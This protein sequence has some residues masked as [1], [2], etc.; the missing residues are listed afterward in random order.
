[1]RP[2]FTERMIIGLVIMRVVITGFVIP[3]FVF[4]I[5]IVGHQPPGVAYV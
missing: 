1:M 2:L 3:D 5:F 4:M